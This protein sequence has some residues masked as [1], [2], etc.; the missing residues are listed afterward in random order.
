MQNGDRVPIGTYSHAMIIID[1]AFHTDVFDLFAILGNV[2]QTDPGMH[3]ILIRGFDCQTIGNIQNT[4]FGIQ[5]GR[6]RFT[7]YRCRPDR[8]QCVSIVSADSVRP[9][10]ADID[11]VSF[12]VKYRS[13]HTRLGFCLADDLELFW[14]DNEDLFRCV[15][16]HSG[17]RLLLRTLFVPATYMHIFS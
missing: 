16:R 2:Q 11:S 10:V 4:A 15:L 12:C 14:I 5:R 3:L 1:A 6:S 13:T 7:K 9:A 17:C 8:L